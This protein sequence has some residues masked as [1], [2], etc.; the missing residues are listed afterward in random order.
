MAFL[1]TG[2]KV[3]SGAVGEDKNGSVVAGLVDEV[4][5]SVHRVSVVFWIEK[6]D[7]QT[8]GLGELKRDVCSVLQKLIEVRRGVLGCG[9]RWRWRAR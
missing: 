5:L 3:D 7:V 8:C 9:V 6:G 4:C 2:A 1:L